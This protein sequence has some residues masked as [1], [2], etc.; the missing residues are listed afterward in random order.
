MKDLLDVFSSFFKIGA[1]TFGGGY[2]MIPL[3]EDEVVNKRCWVDKEDFLDILTVSQSLPGAISVNCSLFVGNNLYGVKGAVAALLGVALPSFLI[4]LL[5]ATLFMSIRDNV[6][7]NAI[8]N[9]INSG[10][11]VLVL[12]GVLS[13]S[14]NV[15]KN[16]ENIVIF[17]IAIGLLIIDINPIIVL[18]VF[19]I[20]GGITYK[21]RG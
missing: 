6:Y 19:A 9:G 21:N 13:I 7:V 14:K 16:K 20:Y 11:P 4:I 5:V 17:L 15:E 12:A 18:G 10:V 1:F 8:F 3:I 2:A